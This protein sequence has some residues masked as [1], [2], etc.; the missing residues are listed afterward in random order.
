MRDSYLAG[1]VLGQQVHL[2]FIIHKE[3]SRFFQQRGE[4]GGGVYS[5]CILHK[6]PPLFRA[7]MTA[8]H[9]PF[10]TLHPLLP[11]PGLGSL[12]VGGCFLMTGFVPPRGFALVYVPQPPL[13]CCPRVL[14]PHGLSSKF[15]ATFL[16][17]GWPR[18][19]WIFGVRGSSAL[20]S[21]PWL[22]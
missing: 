9:H 20:R 18:I 22:V 14:A 19:I 6:V 21:K 5:L 2:I 11:G 8:P 17:S 7:K 16:G 12:H 3:S 10:P 1:E 15:S 13:I 4:D